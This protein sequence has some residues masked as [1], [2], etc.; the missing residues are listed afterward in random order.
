MELRFGL[1]EIVQLTDITVPRTGD[2]NDSV[3]TRALDD[4]SSWIDGY[5]SSRYP[6]P[7]TH[8]VAVD[9]L[10]YHC[11]SAARHMLMTV[12][13]DDA[14]VAA[15]KEARDYL[16]A[17]AKGQINLLPPSAPDAGPG[18]T[19]EFNPGTK[20]FGRDGWGVS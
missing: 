7:V 18:D 5:L 12:A 9:L 4:A 3:L 20:H 10:R 17:V 19:V 8:A 6:V 13:P 11:C 16:M 15:W 14:A 1:D 2:V